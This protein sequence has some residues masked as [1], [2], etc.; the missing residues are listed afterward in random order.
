M[1]PAERGVAMVFQSYALYPHMTAYKNMAFGLKIA[2]LSKAEIGE[3]I[4]ARR[5][6]SRSKN[7][8]ADCLRIFPAGSGSGWLSGARSC[9]SRGCSFSTSPFPILMRRCASRHA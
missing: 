5:K 6:L 3:R 1:E 9:A 2:G 8:L 7:Y 4:R